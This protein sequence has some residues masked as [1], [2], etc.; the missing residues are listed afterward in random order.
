M[1]I[2]VKSINFVKRVTRYF[3]VGKKLDV[4]FKPVDVH[5]AA[6]N[7]SKASTHEKWMIILFGTSYLYF[8]K[9]REIELR[10]YKDKYYLF[11]LNNVS[12][13][14]EPKEVIELIRPIAPVAVASFEAKRAHKEISRKLCEAVVDY[15]TGLEYEGFAKEFGGIDHL[16]QKMFD[17]A[18][19]WGN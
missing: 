19:E 7:T 16:K 17:L 11:Q 10:H 1:F 6:L 18:D 9:G 4:K 14:L 3:D 12:K 13:S 8:E 5:T 2:S 15:K